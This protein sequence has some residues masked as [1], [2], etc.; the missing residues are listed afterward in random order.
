M[1]RS[2]RAVIRPERAQLATR[3]MAPGQGRMI[4]ERGRGAPREE[5]PPRE[6]A[7]RAGAGL[8]EAVLTPGGD[9]EGARPSGDGAGL[10][11]S[12]K[13]LVGISRAGFRQGA[14]R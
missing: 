3:G 4:G 1:L 8:P 6:D 13:H 14:V 9:V 2:I 5:P 11:P 7:R 12:A 10:P